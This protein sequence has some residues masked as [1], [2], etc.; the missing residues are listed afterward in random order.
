M[1]IVGD[2]HDDGIEVRTCAQLAIVRIA[3]QPQRPDRT[4]TARRAASALAGSAVH[5]AHTVASSSDS[6]ASR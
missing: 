5:T 2:R 6:R 1:Q 3:P 4:P